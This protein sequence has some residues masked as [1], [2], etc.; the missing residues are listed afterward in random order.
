MVRDG[1]Q[2]RGTTLV[3]ILVVLAIVGVVMSGAIM[4][5]RSILRSEER[6]TASRLA[7]AIRYSYD[8]AISTGAYYRLHFNLDDQTYKLEAAKDRVLLVREK[9]R[10]GR[11]G[12]GLDQDKEAEQRE[13][14]EKQK[15]GTTDNLPPELLPPPSPKRARFEDF[16]DTT[17]PEVKLK[18]VQILDIYTPRQPEPYEKGHAYLHFFPDG[19]TERA[20]IHVG[21][22]RKDEDDQYS[23]IVQALTG[24]VEVVPGRVRPPNDFDAVDDAGNVRPDR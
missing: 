15:F 11:N 18:R 13:A 8:R 12:V 10:A 21:V 7:A 14:E 2:A 17:L 9:E 4:G 16:K 22:D 20:I 24:R 3:E 6:G 1:A 5:I 23:L 19:H